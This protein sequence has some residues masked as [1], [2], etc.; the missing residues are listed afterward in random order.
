MK[1]LHKLKYYILTVV[2]LTSCRSHDIISNDE[3]VFERAKQSD[4]LSFYFPASLNNETKR[5]NPSYNNFEQ[6]WYSSALYSFKEPI[7]QNKKDL[8]TIYR[9]LWLR[10]FHQ[11]VCFTIKKV[12]QRYYL[13]TKM[14]DR[15]PSFYTNIILG[16]TNDKGEPISDT[17]E[18]EDRLAYI[19]FKEVLQLRESEGKYFENLLEKITF[20][21]LPSIDRSN[22]S[23]DGSQWVVEGYKNGKY[24][25]VERQN[26]EN[27]LRECG[28]Y[29][30]NISS[31][32]IS[33]RDIY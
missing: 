18:K 6:K 7:L 22:M 9:I 28:L 8:G 23:T 2:I 11:P 25:F 29:L 17:L 20:W 15:Q 3:N 31:L 13:S 26:G 10:S 5:K 14:L 27:G 1:Q 16:N 32:K 30:L 19:I 12:D 21:N 4:S 33:S 24:N